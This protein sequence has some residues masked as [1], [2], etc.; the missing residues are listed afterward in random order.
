[1]DFLSTDAMEIT[2]LALNGLSARHKALSANIANADTP[3]YQRIDV[4]F[5]DQ[6]AKIMNQVNEINNSNTTG[7]GMQYNQS[8]LNDGLSNSASQYSVAE[9]I[10]ETYGSFRPE[11]TTDENAEPRLS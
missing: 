4:V 8:C 2:T 9:K 3:G 5:E 7:I 11:I 10:K 6:L 1:M